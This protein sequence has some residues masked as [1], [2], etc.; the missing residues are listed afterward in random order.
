MS[1]C[2]F[3]KLRMIASRMSCVSAS[4]KRRTRCAMRAARAGSVG[5]KGRASTR[6]LSEKNLFDRRFALM[7]SILIP[8]F[9][10]A[11]NPQI[12][13]DGLASDQTRDIQTT[14]ALSLRRIHPLGSC[15]TAQRT[16]QLPEFEQNR[17]R[18]T[19]RRFHVVEERADRRG[20][21]CLVGRCHLVEA[22]FKLRQAQG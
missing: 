5:R 7:C 10:W 14:L 13:L 4:D 18:L 8:A 6:E 2:R 11:K 1:R 19:E 21:A 3:Q 15:I 22:L 17:A 16:L 12:A 9:V 20:V